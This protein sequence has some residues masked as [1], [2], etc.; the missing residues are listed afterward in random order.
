MSKFFHLNW[1]VPA[2]ITLVL[3]FAAFLFV[4]VW[5]QTG[6]SWEAD[7]SPSW[8]CAPLYIGAFCMVIATPVSLI[9]TV[10]AFVRTIRGFGR[11]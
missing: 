10:V 6:F 11:L 5:W 4:G 8:Y 7:I 2:L 1:I 9:W 3:P